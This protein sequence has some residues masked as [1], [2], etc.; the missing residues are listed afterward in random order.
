MFN[1][2]GNILHGEDARMPPF[3]QE[4]EGPWDIRGRGGFGC[5]TEKKSTNRTESSD[6]RGVVTLCIGGGQ[7]IALALEGI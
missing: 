5:S 2:P 1:N 6:M 7:G 4:P 3:S